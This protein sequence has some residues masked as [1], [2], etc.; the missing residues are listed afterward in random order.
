MTADERDCDEN[1]WKQPAHHTEN[2]M[3]VREDLFTFL[4]SQ[5]RYGATQ[6]ELSE[7]LNECV[8]VARDTGKPATLTLT[9]KIVPDARGE[10]T[11]KIE[12]RAVHK[13]PVFERGGTV[14]YGTPDGNLQREDP[15]QKSLDL[16]ALTIERPSIFKNPEEKTA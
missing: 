11:Y 2:F 12:D 5:L 14:M 7:K 13:L 16:R 9:L 15:R 3:A 6:T 1:R 8:N 10:G 4:V